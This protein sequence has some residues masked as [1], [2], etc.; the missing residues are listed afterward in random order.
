M[1]KKSRAGLSRIRRV[2]CCIVLT[3]AIITVLPWFAKAADDQSSP[4]NS[5]RI[6]VFPYLPALTID[7]LYSPIAEA[8]SFELDRLVKL[9]TKA[10]FES[11]KAAL[12]DQSYDIIF[13]HPFF[14][15]DAMDQYSYIP[16]A[17]LAKPLHAILAVEGDNPAKSLEDLLGGTIGLPPKLSAVSD[18]IKTALVDAGVRPGLDVGIRHFRNKASCVQAVV[19][20][21]VT[22]CGLP[23]FVLSQ[24]ED[25]RKKPLRVVYKAPPVSHFAFAVHERVPE[26]ERQKLTDL[27]LSWSD[28][29]NEII[30][31]TGLPD[32]FV[33]ALPDD[34]L[35]VR[36][37]KARLQTF[38]SR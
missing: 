27:L 19:L 4:K 5:Y 17:R 3:I 11:F 6:G 22:A 23:S 10:S 7:R 26:A 24:I 25:F 35:S 34:Y 13:V 33:R 18:L 32:G 36:A 12:A 37:H 15:I 14:L 16:V 30:Q 31:S 1:R 8:F 9:R 38:A 21:G 2:I 28:Q 20:G 29:E